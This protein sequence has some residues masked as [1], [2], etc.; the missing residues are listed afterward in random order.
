LLCVVLLGALLAACTGGSS[1]S[2]KTYHFTSATRTGGLIPAAQRKPAPAFTGELLSGG[3]TSLKA[4]A[5]KVTVVNFWASWCGPCKVE[6]PQFALL[7]NQLKTQGVAFLGIDTKDDKGAAQIFVKQNGIGYPIVYDQ[8]G[9]T[10][11]T[12]G[13]IPANLPFTV[14]VDK[15]QRVAAVYFGGMTVPDLRPPI[16][17][18]VAEG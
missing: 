7:S 16:Q 2:A 13:N 4:S 6:T 17:R 3:H 11:I 8:Q 5:G 14:L 15:K 18:L 12:L 1:G 10:A 9:R